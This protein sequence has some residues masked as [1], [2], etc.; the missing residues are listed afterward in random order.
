MRVLFDIRHLPPMMLLN[1]PAKGGMKMVSPN[2]DDIN[3]ILDSKPKLSRTPTLRDFLEQNIK[4]NLSKFTANK[5]QATYEAVK[6]YRVKQRTQE[7]LFGKKQ[8]HTPASRDAIVKHS[9]EWFAEVVD[10]KLDE[11]GVVRP[12]E[13]IGVREAIVRMGVERHVYKGRRLVYSRTETK[14]LR[15]RIKKEG[16]YHGKMEKWEKWAQRTASQRSV[17]GLKSKAGR[18]KREKR[19]GG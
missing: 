14:A 7:K 12:K 15:I 6:N 19:R 2:P 8:Y 11:M 13:R 9:Q 17:S 1:S 5:K 16:K 4:D 10:E 3:K 18:L